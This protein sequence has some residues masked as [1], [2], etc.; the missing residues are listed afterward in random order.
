MKCIFLLKLMATVFSLT[1]CLSVSASHY[2]LGVFPHLPVAQLIKVYG[3]IAKDFQQLLGHSV[4]M[5]SAK[6]FGQFIQKIKQE[7]FDIAF[8]QPF[9]YP[10]A[11]QFGYY[12]VAK[13]GGV[14]R[15][16]TIVR[17]DS[18]L[19]GIEELKNKII[20]GPPSTAAVTRLVKK[21]LTNQGIDFDNEV[22]FIY[23]RSH[24]SCVRK[25]VTGKADACMTAMLPVRLSGS[26]DKNVKILH[27]TKPF[28]MPLF[29]FHERLPKDH[30]ELLKKQILSW[31]ENHPVRKIFKTGSLKPFTIA[32]DEEYDVIH[33][34][35]D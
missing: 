8:I 35:G 24:F 21:A 32:T 22:T 5:K 23:T 9:D 17:K 18:A 28:P 27:K 33:Q 7:S 1:A 19:S 20:A 16:I 34:F 14:L 4:S 31:G 15:A 12:P 11:K 30:A 2:R 26:L 6:N 10:T 25:V 29:V 3:P 13:R